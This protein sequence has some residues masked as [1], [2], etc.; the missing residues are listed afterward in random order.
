VVTNENTPNSV[1][2]ASKD[3]D[4]QVEVYDPDPDRALEIAMSGAVRPVE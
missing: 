3:S 4:V 1:Y 2:I